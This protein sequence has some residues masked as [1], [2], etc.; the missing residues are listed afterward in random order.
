ML[1]PLRL[2]FSSLL[3]VFFLAACTDAAPVVL[4]DESHNQAFLIGKSDPLDLSDL[5]GLYQAE[6]FTVASH[7]ETLTKEVLDSVD[8]LVI[9]G[10]FRALAAEEVEAVVDFIKAGGGLA[11][12]LHIA[13]PVGGLLERLDVDYT[14]G[15]LR[16]RSHVIDETPLNFKVNVLKDHPITTGLESF[17]AYG[18]WAL[19]GTAPHAVILAETSP[20]AWVDLDRDNRFS[21]N[22][23]EQSFGVMVAGEIDRGRYVVVG[24]D[25]IFQNRFLDEN[26]RQLALQMLD[27]LAKR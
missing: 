24:D 13:P 7:A 11:V 9:S 26:N 8:V 2:F 18:V 16:E 17:S 15:T 21:G 25:A 22:D 12:M 5:A 23:A 19:R 27:W 4:F 3:S 10:P 6:G 1:F 20:K 14:N